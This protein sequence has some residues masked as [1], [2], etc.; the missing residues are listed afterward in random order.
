MIRSFPFICLIFLTLLSA[1]VTVE[2]GQLRAYRGEDG[3]IHFTDR[4][5]MPAE[6]NHLFDPSVLDET[7]LLAAEEKPVAPTENRT[8]ASLAH[9][10][11]QNYPTGTVLIKHSQPAILFDDS[12]E[13]YGG[14]TYTGGISKKA[15]K[16]NRAKMDRLFKRYGRSLNLDPN[17]LKA[18]AKVESNFNP[19][20]RSH[21][22]AQGLMQLM[23][24]T[25]RD[26]GV[27]NPYDPEQ[28]IYGG[29]LYLKKQLDRFGSL[30][31]AL[32]AYNAGPNTVEKYRG[33]PPYKET[34]N[35]IRKVK[36]ALAQYRRG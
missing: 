26:L 23:P 1:A 5:I 28:A 22:G 10:A 20:A 9:T 13:F 11:V 25:A 12:T 29:S 19:R 4:Q 33:V 8:R 18:V 3:R 15:S 27:S 24:D 34:R 31:L 14:E 30:E 35:Y 32:A 17:L 2:A 36:R 21:K 16:K 6:Y 7:P